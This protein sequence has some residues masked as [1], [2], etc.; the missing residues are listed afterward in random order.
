MMIFPA[1]GGKSRL[2]DA[3]RLLDAIF[4]QPGSLR[5]LRMVCY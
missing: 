5:A 4:D 2:L 1:I 3:N